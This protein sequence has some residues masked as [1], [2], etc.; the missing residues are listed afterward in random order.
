MKD[1][2]VGAILLAAGNSSRFGANKLLYEI[3]GKPLVQYSMEIISQLPF[4][5][6]IVVTQY[7]QVEQLAKRLGL[8][9]VRNENPERGI[10]HSIRLGLEKQG[11]MDGW[12]FLVGDQPWLCRKTVEKLLETF[13]ES[14][15]GMAAVRCGENI[16]NPVIFSRTY[17]K[18]LEKLSG[19]RGGKKI[20]LLHR[21]DVEFVAAK[22]EELVD[23]DENPHENCKI[24]RK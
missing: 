9:W 24:R 4:E 14:L 18:E 12:M 15:R 6:K 11:D 21:E 7:P 17:K 5:Q 13:R 23:L 3:E 10:S 19:D 22:P 20:L 1:K 2:K 8:S 16:G